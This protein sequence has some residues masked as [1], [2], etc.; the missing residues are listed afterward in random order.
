MSGSTIRRMW[1]AGAVLGVAALQVLAVEPQSEP[2]DMG[3]A[4]AAGRPLA[5]GRLAKEALQ[6]TGNKD[7]NLLYEAGDVAAMNGDESLALS[8]FRAFVELSNEKGPRMRRALGYVLARGAYPEGLSK[9]LTLL[10]ADEGAWRVGMAFVERSLADGVPDQ[11]VAGAELLIKHYAA[12]TGKMDH[13]AKRI[14]DHGSGKYDKDEALRLRLARAVVAMLAAD[15]YQYAR[16][17]DTLW[18]KLEPAVRLELVLAMQKRVN[19]PLHGHIV[20]WFAALTELP[21]AERAAAGRA[22]LALEPIYRDKGTEVDYRNYVWR[23]LES[24]SVFHVAG[25]ELVNDAAIQQRMDVLVSKVKA[26]ADARDVLKDFFHRA[27]NNYLGDNR[28]AQIALLQKHAAV[29]HPERFRELV[30][31][32]EGKQ[33][34]AQVGQWVQGEPAFRAAS[35]KY[36]VLDWYNSTGDAQGLPVAA[37]EAMIARPGHWSV[38]HIATHFVG[39]G[40]VSNDVKVAVLQA[41]HAVE[42]SSPALRALV[43][44]VEKGDKDKSWAQHAGFTA[45]KAAVA[46]EKPAGDPAR[47]AYLAMKAIPRNQGNPDAAVYATA[48]SFLKSYTGKIPGTA[49]GAVTVEEWLANRLLALHVDHVT[50]NKDQIGKA[51]A[52]WGERV[53]S[54]GGDC[55]YLIRRTH[56]HGHRGLLWPAAKHYAA[57]VRQGQ[58]PSMDIL[59][60]LGQTSPSGEAVSLFDGMYDKLGNTALAWINGHMHPSHAPHCR[61]PFAFYVEQVGKV[62]AT[63]GLTFGHADLR[64]CIEILWRWSTPEV[65]ASEPT[66]VALTDRLLAATP[67]GPDGTSLARLYGCFSR[68]GRPEAARRWF[69]ATMPKLQSRPAW[70]R[71]NALLAIA[72]QGEPRSAANRAHMLLTV[73]KPLVESVPAADRDRLVFD[74]ALLPQCAALAGDKE[75]PAR[76]EAG[77][78]LYRRFA[79]LALTEGRIGWDPRWVVRHVVHGLTGMVERGE[80]ARVCRALDPYT[81]AAAREPTWNECRRLLVDPVVKALEE[82]EAWE[83]LFG[84]ASLMQGR[85]A[86]ENEAG[87]KECVAIKSRAARHIDGLLPV[88]KS[89]PTYDLHLAAQLLGMGNETRAWELAQPK[90]VLLKEKWQ[91]MDPAFVAWV[92]DRMRR[93]HL[94]QPALDFAFTVLMKERAFEAGIMARVSLTKGDVYRDQENFQAARIE[95]QG[96]IDTSRY[97]QTEAGLAARYRLIELMIQ[98][99]DYAGA[100]ARLQRLVDAGT[101]REQAEAYYLYAKMAFDQKEYSLARDH[102]RDVFR[103]EHGHVQGRLL[104]G[105]LRLLLPRGLAST[106]VA[107]GRLD[108]QTVA[109]PGRDLTLKLQDR[110]LSVARG[111]KAIPV[112]IGTTRGGDEENLKLLVSPD[113]ES[114]FTG[115]IATR[116]GDALKNNLVLELMGDEEVTYRIDPEF[117]KANET[118]YPAKRLLI[119]SD[120]ELVASAGEILSREEREQRDTERRL[121]AAARSEQSA[122]QRDRRDTLVRPGSPIHVQ[123]TD[124]DRDVSAQADAVTVKLET[125]SGDLLEGFPLTETAPHSGIFEGV[126]PTAIPFPMASASDTEEGKDPNSLINNT[127]PESWGSVADG[128]H[129]K[130]LEVDTMSSHNIR[131]VS[132]TT[133]DVGRIRRVR[134]LGSLAEELGFLAA[135]PPNTNTVAGGVLVEMGNGSQVSPDEIRRVLRRHA[136]EHFALPQPSFA[137]TDTKI[138]KRNGWYITRMSGVFWL[139]ENRFL[140][141]K[142]IQDRTMHDWQYAYLFIDG[143][144]VMG[145]CMRGDTLKRSVK[146]FLTRGAHRLEVLFRDHW[147]QS[148]VVVGYLQEDGTEAPLPPEWFSTEANPE[149]VALV[150]PTAT[151]EKTETGFTAEMEEPQRLRRVRWVFEDFDGQAVSATE[152]RMVDEA[153]T[154]VMPSGRDFTMGRENRVLEVAA[155]D[156]IDI[157]YTDEHR[158]DPDNPQLTAHLGASFANAT[159]QLAYEKVTPTANGDMTTTY[160]PARRGR[161]GDRLMVMVTDYDEDRTDARDTVEVIIKTSSGET[162]LVQALETR[163]AQHHRHGSDERAGTFMQVLTLGEATAGTTIKLMPGDTV[164]AFYVDRENTDPGVP[165]EREYAIVDAG[166]I[167]PEMSVFRTRVVQEEDRS[168]RARLTIDRLRRQGLD[169]A[170]IHVLTDVVIGAAVMPEG[171]ETSAVPV[172]AEGPVLL[173]VVHPSAAL[174][175]E[176][177]CVV[178]AVAESERAAAAAEG[179]EPRVVE[180]SMRLQDAA[181]LAQQKGFPTRLTDRAPQSEDALLLEGRFAGVLRL[182]LGA[183]GDEADDRLSTDAATLGQSPGTP[184]VSGVVDERFRVPTIV[185]SGNDMVELSVKSE[186]GQLFASRRVELRSDARVELMD[187]SYTVPADAI[188]LGQKFYIGVSD[189][190]RD[191]SPER[192]VIELTVLAEGGDRLVLPLQETLPHSGIFSGTLE[193]TFI[194]KDAQGNVTPPNVTND[195]LQVQFGESVTFTYTDTCS[196][197]AEE[198]TNVVAQGKI[199]DGADGRMASFTKR[200]KD[201][202]MAVKTRF[203]LAESLFEMAK[204]QRKLKQEEKAAE[205]IGE[206]KRILEEAMRDYPDTSLVA[207]GEF[208]LA[209]LAQ[210]LANYQEAIGRYSRV[211][212][213]W[214]D[215]DYASRSQFKKAICLE[216]MEHY[217]QACEEYVKLTYLY[218][219]S[220]LVADAT[221]R[222]GNYYYTHAQYRTAGRIFERFQERHPEHELAVKALFL[223]GQSYMKLE[224]EKTEGVPVDYLDAIVVFARLVETYPDSTEIRPEAMYWLGDSYY[225]NRDYVKAY[226]TLKKLTWDYPTTKWAKIA[227]G[228]LTEE[229]FSRIEE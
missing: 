110:N 15:M 46:Q 98:T 80:W 193:P 109:V 28:D 135:F 91:E 32:T 171:N 9:R 218:P 227:R 207:Q 226:Q 220:P 13:L 41:V 17:L 44:E 152:L 130:W 25:A 150:Q 202:E 225:R 47:L 175:A 212:S 197:V 183:P 214:P 187:R 56:E 180:V 4:L 208:L 88:D 190:D 77:Q 219:N 165:V 12:G 211:I 108:L 10:G 149:L 215:S 134:L 140:T 53:T 137:R 107:I 20:K 229:A 62:L 206:G 136:F 3:A 37:K 131:Q 97:K 184:T 192:E 42:G 112:R 198:P 162:L 85:V 49:H 60:R 118:D 22:F 102:L 29:L 222:L 117:Q 58:S 21:E 179:R 125:S 16:C 169:E 59:W 120:A 127:R 23:L 33:F 189:P 86:A 147:E 200:F 186:S 103:R 30:Q 133:P 113:D 2:K 146:R 216:K 87:V 145:G 224:T 161:T 164:T 178:R 160:V 72:G 78:A 70:Q 201:P 94:F 143:K 54:I 84:F 39:S 45:L 104:E 191:S 27:L 195:T 172:S 38:T 217:E 167:P 166:D 71:A 68:T 174:H 8:R 93:Q 141:L 181:Q 26:R 129:G 83:L 31:W 173:E 213:G 123:V 51:A 99:K 139:P 111:G 122:W 151:I 52:L 43:A 124:L 115:T 1:M 79:E 128:A 159:I 153:G 75:D 18:H 48:E 76:Q 69:D 119:K 90:L 65:N 223:A 14:A 203:L 142:W 7:A 228:R 170:D 138:G 155:G 106:E 24:P 116:L 163:Y 63:P 5:A 40:V 209:N 157:A 126:V 148:Q 158:L 57:L 132:L 35:L 194:E 182:Q 144:Y 188:H 55:D 177:R 96:L 199:Y 221:V 73:G 205:V 168:P 154:V 6:R 66:V 204:D 11:A 64:P 89:D 105:E 34:A 185:V 81:A 95:Y 67:E 36:H 101:L 156:R 210:E 82:A 100:D 92:I 114:L 50:H 121:A 19:A 196:L 61:W 176:S 74:Q